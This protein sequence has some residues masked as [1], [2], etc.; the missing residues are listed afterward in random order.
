M[1]DA[2]NATAS[3]LTGYRP[4][5]G[6]E[7]KLPE[8]PRRSSLK[9]AQSSGGEREETPADKM[10]RFSPS[11]KNL[12]KDGEANGEVL[13]ERVE[14]SPAFDVRQD[15]NQPREHLYESVERRQ[16]GTHG[17]NGHA[18]PSPDQVRT[19][20]RSSQI[21]RGQIRRLCCR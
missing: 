4:L 12:D 18:G 3:Q 9:P 6:E 19:V 15:K 20:Y 10:I 14:H 21:L 8:L 17:T 11:T 5:S 7:E 1:H 2:T 13:L 16:N